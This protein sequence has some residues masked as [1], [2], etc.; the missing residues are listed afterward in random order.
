[1][2]KIY[3][4][5]VKIDLA[6]LAATKHNKYKSLAMETPDAETGETQDVV[7]S[8]NSVVD[9]GEAQNIVESN[10][11]N[12]FGSFSQIK[13][14]VM[15]P[16]ARLGYFILKPIVRPGAFRLR[17]YL[18]DGLRQDILQ[19]NR[20]LINELHQEIRALGVLLQNI[21]SS[22][23]VMQAEH[24]IFSSKKTEEMPVVRL[25]ET[26]HD[27]QKIDL[28]KSSVII[29][30]AGG[31]AK[32]CI[33]LLREMGE[34]IAFCIG[35]SDSPEKCLGVKVLNGDEH[36]A[37]L[38]SEGYYKIFIA[39]GSN[40]LRHSLGSYAQKLGFHLINAISTRAVISPTVKLGI[41]I[42]VMAGAV[43]NAEAKIDDLAIINTGA[44][45]D[46]DC[47]IGK[48]VHLAPQSAL[49]GNVVIGDYS[50]LGIGSNVIPEINIGKNVMVGAGGVVISDIAS[51]ITVVGVPAR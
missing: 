3:R 8:Y 39:I 14:K 40:K 30:G 33:E 32:V 2:N 18:I 43:I 51:D 1:M 38:R 31:H 16:I 49:A 48:A 11:H 10:E 34:Q 9:I 37:R 24:K 23:D 17:R 15:R 22:I 7:E 46:H 6:F 45:V 20:N 50:F 41:G 25:N 4:S 5:G 28:M 13:N 42:A 21:S 47:K 26:M 35:N 12:S 36:L 27:D 44:T 19:E 29:V